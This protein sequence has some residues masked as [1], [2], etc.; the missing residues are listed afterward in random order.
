M[1]TANTTPK[2]AT[3]K[4]RSDRNHIIYELI[5]GGLNYI[6]VTAKTES[7][8]MRSVQ[9]R[10][11]KHWY[12]AQKESKD[13]SLCV[14]LRG[15]SSRDEIEIRVHEIVR[16][17]AAAHRREVEIRRAIRPALNTDVRGD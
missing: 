4:R 3:R 11:N 16:G 9:V 12:R 13:W 15:L 8:V 10:A 7:T 5:V 1:D 14:A 2:A 6:G 17:K